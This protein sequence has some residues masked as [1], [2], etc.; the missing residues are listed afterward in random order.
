MT[1]LGVDPGLASTGYGVIELHGSRYHH[2]C[3][4]VITTRSDCAT[5]ERLLTIQDRLRKVIRDH[6]PSVAGVEAL[7]FGRNARTALPVAQAR[8]VIL[9]TL[10]SEHVA[11]FEYPPRVIKQAV[12][13]S[14]KA[15]KHQVQEMIRVIFRLKHAPDT[16]HA[17]DALAVAFCHTT[18]SHIDRIADRIAHEDDRVQ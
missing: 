10:A 4:G 2:V 13:G 9:C 1:I 5:G 15:E 7:Y 12:V 6:R 17:A 18:H 11:S 16:D 14:G 8:G 3:H